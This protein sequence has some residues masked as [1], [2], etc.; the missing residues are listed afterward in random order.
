MYVLQGL[1]KSLVRKQV[2][3]VSFF[4]FAQKNIQLAI[5]FGSTVPPDSQGWWS[6]V[7]LSR[8]VKFLA[9]D[10]SCVVVHVLQEDD[11]GGRPYSEPVP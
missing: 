11:S 5:K 1:F 4:D 8:N 6:D 10:L 2:N 7:P 3:S 9:P